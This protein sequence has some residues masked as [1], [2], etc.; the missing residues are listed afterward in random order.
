[1]H[2][3]ACTQTHPLSASIV[4]SFHKKNIRNSI[5]CSPTIRLL[6][7]LHFFPEHF[8]VLFCCFPCILAQKNL[9]LSTYWDWDFIWFLVNWD[10]L[11]IVHC[12]GKRVPQVAEATVLNGKLPFPTDSLL[13]LFVSHAP[14][15]TKSPYVLLNSKSM[16]VLKLKILTIHFYFFFN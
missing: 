9:L 16:Y 1:M 3:H 15:L 5:W 7:M 6:G 2:T 11:L 8:F 13:S 12:A 14:T 4:S 10:T